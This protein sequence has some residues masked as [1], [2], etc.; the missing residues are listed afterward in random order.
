MW[1]C[2]ST[3][4]L[5]LFVHAQVPGRQSPNCLLAEHEAWEIPWQSS[6]EDS[7]AFTAKGVGSIP[8]QETAIP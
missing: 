6:I 4:A 8:G 3:N 7:M 5:I 2:L 1:T